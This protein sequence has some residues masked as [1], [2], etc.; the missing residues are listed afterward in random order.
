MND[1]RGRTAFV[2]G[3]ASGIGLGLAR[4]FGRAGAQVVLSDVEE[5]ALALATAALNSEGL[6][7]AGEAADVTRLEDLQRAAAG[8]LKAFGRIDVVCNNAG[9]VHERALD[10]WTD[11]GW[12]WVLDVNLMGAV[13]GVQAFLPIFRDQGFGHFVNTSS[14]TGVLARAGIS[15]YA[16]TKF[17]LV[18]L[19]Q[20]LREELAP[21]GIGVTVLCPGRVDTNIMAALRNAPAAVRQRSRPLSDPPLP[22]PSAEAVRSATDAVEVGEM[23]IDAI[24]AGR[25]YAFTDL[26]WAEA[27]EA[28]AALRAA[29][30]DDLRAWERTRGRPT[31][32]TPAI[33]GAPQLV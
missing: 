18:G 8:A 24:E 25:F 6:L 4:A 2:T 7:A 12:R 13:H 14:I 21:Q 20:S 15:Q 11:A 10:D 30:M 3:A 19:S 22:P 9:V 32:R 26:T 33:A 16:A 17:A 27:V 23:V 29:A 5:E 1:W 31:D 28:E